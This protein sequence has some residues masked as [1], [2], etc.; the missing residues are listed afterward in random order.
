MAGFLPIAFLPCI[1]ILALLAIPAILAISSHP[2][3]P[4]QIVQFLICNGRIELFAAKT[5]KPIAKG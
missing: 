2:P 3:S 4:A 1:S 5:Q